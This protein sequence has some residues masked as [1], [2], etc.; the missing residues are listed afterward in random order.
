MKQ[1]MPHNLASWPEAARKACKKDLNAV[2]KGLEAVNERLQRLSKFLNQ[3]MPTAIMRRRE[4]WG[5][6]ENVG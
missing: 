4:K 3:D 1:A 5:A 6:P 2:A